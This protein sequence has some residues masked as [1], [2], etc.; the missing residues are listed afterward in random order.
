[1]PRLPA[2]RLLDADPEQLIAMLA[3]L[4]EALRLKTMDRDPLHALP[5]VLTLREAGEFLRCHPKTVVAWCSEYA[6]PL[7]GESHHKTIAK[8]D[9]RDLIECLRGKRGRM[10]TQAG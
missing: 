2:G 4:V 1:M 6:I 3:A 10:K 8:S 5:E 9:L 7:M